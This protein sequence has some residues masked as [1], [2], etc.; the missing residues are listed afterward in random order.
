MVRNRTKSKLKHANHALWT[1]AVLSMQII[2]AHAQAS[3]TTKS[4]GPCS[5]PVNGNHNKVTIQCEVA[6]ARGKQMVAILNRILANQLDPADVMAKLDEILAATR[7]SQDQADSGRVN[8]RQGTTGNNSPI[9]NSPITVGNT[10]LAFTQEQRTEII[11]KLS[12]AAHKTTIAVVATQFSAGSKF[13]FDL[14]N[15]FKESG[16]SMYTDGVISVMA[17]NL[18]SSTPMPSVIVKVHGDPSDKSVPKDIADSLGYVAFVFDKVNLPKL[19]SH[20]L[21]VPEGEIVIS[22]EGK[23]E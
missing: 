16:W 23:I 1:V 3:N 6:P 19:I 18:P 5:P 21:T 2:Q 17:L 22:F 11:D 20:E 8:V 12:H 13:P 7:A 15:I 4:T 9:I 10:S 14:Y